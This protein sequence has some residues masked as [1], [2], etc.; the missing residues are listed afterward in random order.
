MTTS[1]YGDHPKVLGPDT[2]LARVFPFFESQG[3]CDPAAPGRP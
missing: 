3:H 2:T 1:T